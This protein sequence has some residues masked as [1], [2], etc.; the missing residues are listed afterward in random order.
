MCIY[1]YI[2]M[3][4]YIYILI[5]ILVDSFLYARRT[6][7]NKFTLHIGF[8]HAAIP[9]FVWGWCDDFAWWFS[10]CVSRQPKTSKDTSM[11]HVFP[12]PDS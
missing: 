8:L 1:I 2:C 11:Q 12:G 5:F 3:Y 7:F 6:S 4:I 9:A 10:A